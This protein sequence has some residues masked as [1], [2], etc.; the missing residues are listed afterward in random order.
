[1]HNQLLDT[2]IHLIESE[3][4]Q[5]RECDLPAL[6][7]QIN[8]VTNAGEDYEEALSEIASLYDE[9]KTEIEIHILEEEQFLLPLSRR[10]A[11]GADINY[12]EIE[13]ARHTVEAF[14]SQHDHF[15]GKCDKMM[16]IAEG[17]HRHQ[18]TQLDKTTLIDLLA[19]LKLLLHRHDDKEHNI[20]FPVILKQ[21]QELR[22][23]AQA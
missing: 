2:I 20:L 5:L 16:E 19:D 14:A 3:H 23:S 13:L 10:V 8:V 4:R 12:E 17:I 6:N 15:D 11:E 9:L 7:E 22:N 1:M 21:C 18:E